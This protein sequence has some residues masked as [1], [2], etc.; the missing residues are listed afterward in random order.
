MSRVDKV[1]NLVGGA[2]QYVRIPHHAT[3]KVLLAPFSQHTSPLYE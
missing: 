2:Y 3:L 1:E